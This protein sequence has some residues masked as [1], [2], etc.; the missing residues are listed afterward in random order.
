[1][2]NLYV[3]LKKN[4]RESCSETQLFLHNFVIVLKLGRTNEKKIQKHFAPVKR[5]LHAKHFEHFQKKR[6]QKMLFKFLPGGLQLKLRTL[7]IF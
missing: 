6:H 2:E 1:M 3:L 5:K 7:N 4:Y